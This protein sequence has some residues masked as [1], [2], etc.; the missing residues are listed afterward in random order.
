MGMGT[1]SDKAVATLPQADKTLVS[2]EKKYRLLIENANEIIYT[3][4]P[5]GVITYV[6][7]GMEALLGHSVEQVMGK[8]MDGLIHPDDI[9]L[10]KSFFETVIRTGQKESGV[11]F[12]VLQADGTMALAQFERR[13]RKGRSRRYRS[14]TKASPGT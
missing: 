7:P 8:K 11:E 1:P 14:V 5:E 10:C 4:T 9:P 2:S 3:L 12:R 13:T 6:S